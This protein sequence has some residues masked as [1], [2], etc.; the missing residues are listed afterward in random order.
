[1]ARKVVEQ[2]GEKE[3]KR[4]VKASGKREGKVKVEKEGAVTS[5]PVFRGKRGGRNDCHLGPYK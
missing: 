2:R 4:K 1:M 3:K 5:E